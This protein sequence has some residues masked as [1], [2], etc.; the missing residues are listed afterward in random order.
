MTSIALLILLT[1]RLRTAIS[2]DWVFCFFR[3]GCLKLEGV[4][5]FILKKMELEFL[6]F[7]HF[8]SLCLEAFSERFEPEP[9]VGGV[10]LGPPNLLIFLYCASARGWAGST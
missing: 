3:G 2:S 7:Q 6:F 8:Y 1:L 10:I 4:E 5:R 9:E